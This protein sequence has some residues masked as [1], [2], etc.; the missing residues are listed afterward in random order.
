MALEDRGAQHDKVIVDKFLDPE[1]TTVMNTYDYVL[2]PS[3]NAISGPIWIILPPV[4]E[5]KGRFYSILARAATAINTIT[6]TDRD[7]SECWIQD[8]VLNGKCDKLLLYSDGLAWI[9]CVGPGAWP[10]VLTTAPAGT[11]AA[12]TTRPATAPYTG[13]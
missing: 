2:R 8:I 13:Q 1:V 6:I 4:A 10:G 7:D 11:T 12:P 5:A 9:P 3:A